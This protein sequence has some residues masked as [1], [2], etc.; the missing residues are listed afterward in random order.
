M[1]VTIGDIDKFGIIL[2]MKISVLAL[3]GVFDTGLAIMLDAFGIVVDSP[4]SQAAYMIPSHLAH[5]DPTVERFERWARER[6]AEGFSWMKQRGQRGRA[7]VRSRAVC[8]RS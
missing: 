7:H 2:A 6:L 3:D 8:T 4:P 5:A 1:I